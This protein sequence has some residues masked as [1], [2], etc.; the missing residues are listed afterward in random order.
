MSDVLRVGVVGAGIGAGYIAG[1]QK[2][3][4]VVV[5]A[6]CARTRGR[7]EPIAARYHIPHLYTDYDEMLAR[8]PLDIVVVATPNHL[9]HPMTL[10]ALDAGKHVLCDKPLAL[11]AA[12]AEEMLARATAR[13]RKHFVPFI[14]RFLP[15]AMYIREIIG[16][17]FLGRVLHV[18]VRYY[19]HGW[20]DLFGPMRWQYDKAQ[21]GSGTL[22]N[23]GSHAIHL[24]HWWLGDIT[25]VNAVMSTA[26]SERRQDGGGMAKVNV[27][28]VCAILG[29]LENGAPIVM[30]T[31]SVAL[32]ARARVEIDLFGTEGSLTFQHDW[33]ADYALTGNIVAMRRNDQVPTRVE[34]PARL[35]GEFTDM[36]D[37]YTPVRTNFVRMTAEFVDAIRQDRPA[38]PNFQDGLRVQRVMDAVL[39]AVETKSW[40][41]VK[42]T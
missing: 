41:R 23:L 33:G 9:H 24:I 21:A 25:Q 40:T 34:I 16:T 20:G 37:Y 36:P 27:D 30:H 5:G 12:Q 4:D 18:N 6:L 3:P 38:A 11:N 26:I 15:A 35:K 8:E 22:G 31:S 28:D 32:V 42:G 39:E 1:F 13:G 14:F 19:V 17:G 2:Q 7:M 29:E 10:A